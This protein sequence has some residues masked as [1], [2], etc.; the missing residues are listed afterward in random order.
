MKQTPLYFKVQNKTMCA[1]P[2]DDAV[3]DYITGRVRYLTNMD[4]ISMKLSSFAR[5][6]MNHV[7]IVHIGIAN[8]YRGFGIGACSFDG[9]SRYT[10]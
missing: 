7:I 9:I 1:L 5:K 10:E 8:P 3:V 2:A 4:F 6:D